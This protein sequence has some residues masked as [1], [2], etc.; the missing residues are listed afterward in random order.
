MSSLR[1]ISRRLFARLTGG[2]ALLTGFT[3]TVFAS[4]G[5]D[6]NDEEGTSGGGTSGGYGYGYGEDDGYGYGEDD[7]Y[8]YGYGY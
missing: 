6:G 5:C 7:G 8:G 1:R 2:T 4:S 3:T